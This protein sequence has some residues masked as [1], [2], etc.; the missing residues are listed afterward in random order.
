[1]ECLRC[2]VCCTM[3]QAFVTGED[4]ERITSYLGITIE[5]WKR[6]YDDSRW[7][8]SQYNL[9]CHVNGACAFLTYEG[10]LAV[11]AIQEVK[12]KCCRD[13]EPDPARK[14]CRKGIEKSKN[15]L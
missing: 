7:Q 10:Y 12:P 14:E 3:H 4:I 2:G 6:Q 8:Y 11:C 15:K 13:W 5:E 9:I 1:M